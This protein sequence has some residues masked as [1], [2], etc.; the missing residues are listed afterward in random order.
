MVVVSIRLV[1]HYIGVYFGIKL[2]VTQKGESFQGFSASGLG[3]AK[4][5][6]RVN[7]R[8]L[9]QLWETLLEAFSWILSSL[10]HN[11][12]IVR[13]IPWRFDEFK[14]TMIFLSN[15]VQSRICILQVWLRMSIKVSSWI[16]LKIFTP[17]MAWIAVASEDGPHPIICQKW[18]WPRLFRG[19]SCAFWMCNSITMHTS[20]HVGERPY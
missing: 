18:S 14:H 13:L 7:D 6:V 19:S 3:P 10:H 4:E 20:L 11:I 12:I 15:V 8:C 9:R 5:F 16:M 2:V 1:V 17:S